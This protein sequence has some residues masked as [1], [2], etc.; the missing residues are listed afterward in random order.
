MRFL[1][2]SLACIFYIGSA[3]YAYALG[4]GTPR[5]QSYI[6]QPFSASI[7]ILNAANIGNLTVSVNSTS[8]SPNLIADSLDSKIVVLDNQPTI[9]ISSV[10]PIN[11]PYIVFSLRISDV[12]QALT[13]DFTALLDVSP[14]S[15]VFPPTSVTSPVAA[16]QPN[17]VTPSNSFQRTGNTFSSTTIPNNNN[18]VNGVLGPYEFAVE[19]QIPERFGAVLDGQSLWRV[20][21]RINEAMG[22]SINQM[23]WAL[24]VH[25]RQ[26]FT[27]DS[28]ES[29]QAGQFLTIPTF[30]QVSQFT[31]AEALANINRSSSS[32]PVA[33]PAGT[34]VA[35]APVETDSSVDLPIEPVDEAVA[36]EQVESEVIQDQLED[37][38]FRLSGLNELAESNLTSGSEQ[39]IEAI[40]SLSIVVGNLTQELIRKDRQIEF[41]EE[42]ISTYESITVLNSANTGVPGG[43]IVAGS[44]FDEDDAKITDTQ[45]NNLLI[46]FDSETLGVEE[47]NNAVAVSSVEQTELNEEVNAIGTSTN[48]VV[49]SEDGFTFKPWMLWLGLFSVLLAFVALF[50]KRFAGL[51]F[52]NK[53]NAEVFSKKIRSDDSVDSSYL[54]VDAPDSVDDP[55]EGYSEFSYDGM[56]GF[57]Y[58]DG[59]PFE[60][61]SVASV[62]DYDADVIKDVEAEIEEIEA[63]L[64]I[65]AEEEVTIETTIEEDD[66]GEIEY[67]VGKVVNLKKNDFDEKF[68]KLIENKD[69]E[70]ALT[71]L[72]TQKNNLE[73]EERYYLERLKIYFEERNKEAFYEYYDKIESKMQNF[74][75]AYNYEISAMVVGLEEQVENEV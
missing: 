18:R 10:Q 27:T 67:S 33:T 47:S 19:G 8:V 64:T 22:V 52:L 69:F 20:A 53:E 66:K 4:V 23:M 3:Q 74:S 73:N 42:K 43:S 7:P 55:I 54:E 35:Q 44:G 16:N 34:T 26:A 21:R 68:S 37:D 38:T 48:N 31:D 59:E 50:R 12:N 57:S 62:S 9:L 5:I 13:R 60:F 45:S 29:L 71:F 72:E 15:G 51:F 70:E 32:T 61:N 56:E 6:G 36:E 46:A 39:S 2:T 14:N 25:N 28:V 49:L 65:D 30:A 58:V 1:I 11:E 41:L 40:N 63:E 75:D 24:Y 17:L